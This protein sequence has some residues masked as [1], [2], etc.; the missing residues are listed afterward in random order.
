VSG[1]AEFV[2][3]RREERTLDVNSHGWGTYGG[4]VEKKEEHKLYT[5]KIEMV[6]ETVITDVLLDREIDSTTPCINEKC[7]L[8][9]FTAL[10]TSIHNHCNTSFSSL[11]SHPDIDLERKAGNGNSTP[12]HVACY[13]NNL[14][15]AKVLIDEGVSV[16]SVDRWKKTPLMHAAFHNAAAIVTIL[17]RN[18]ANKR[19]RHIMRCSSMT[20]LELC[21]AHNL[22]AEEVPCDANS[23][24]YQ[25]SRLSF[26]NFSGTTS[27]STSSCGGGCCGKT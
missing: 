26:R 3:E 13:R 14:F 8:D 12:L 20:S 15:A 18:G 24:L 10:H 27:H 1:F 7:S 25:A 9:N 5:T 23:S 11:V 6:D 22:S 17:L 16:N 4:M 19:C 2:K 21:K